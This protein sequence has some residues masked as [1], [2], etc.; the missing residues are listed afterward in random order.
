MDKK[1][2]KNAYSSTAVFGHYVVKHIQIQTTHL[3]LYERFR[4]LLVE[5]L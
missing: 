2:K 5:Y 3:Y 4:I 1:L